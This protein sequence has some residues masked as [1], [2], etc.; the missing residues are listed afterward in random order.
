MA[1]SW[2]KPTTPTLTPWCMSQRSTPLPTCR[3]NWWLAASDRRSTAPDNQTP[4][5]INSRCACRQT[6]TRCSASNTASPARALRPPPR[7]WV[8]QSRWPYLRLLRLHRPVP[9]CASRVAVREF[10]AAPSCRARYELGTAPTAIRL[11]GAGADALCI[12][13]SALGGV[14]QFLPGLQRLRPAQRPGMRRRTTDPASD[15]ADG[16]RHAGNSL[17]RSRLRHGSLIPIQRGYTPRRG[18]R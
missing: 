17:Q 13:A 7:P 14:R 6:L 10:A 5:P 2:D 1:P 16:R 12:G 4:T 18:L 3:C 11:Q 15:R 9:A 8:R